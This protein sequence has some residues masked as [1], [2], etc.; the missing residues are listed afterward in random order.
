MRRKPTIFPR[1]TGRDQAIWK[2]PALPLGLLALAAIAALLFFAAPVAAQDFNGVPTVSFASKQHVVTEP[3]AGETATAQLTV[4]LSHSVRDTVT[5]SYRTLKGNHHPKATPNEDYTAIADGE[6]SIAPGAT[7]GTAAVT[8][9][10]DDAVEGD[11]KFLVQLASAASAGVGKPRYATVTIRDNDMEP[12]PTPT[13]QP[14]PMPALTPVR[15]N[16]PN[17]SFA[18]SQYEVDEPDAGEHAFVELTVR[19]SREVS[20]EVSVNY[21]TSQ[22]EIPMANPDNGHMPVEH[23]DGVMAF[24]PGETEVV[25]EVAVEGDDAAEGDENFQVRLF[26]PSNAMLGEPNIAN[27]TIRDNDSGPGATPGPVH[28]TDVTPTPE[29]TPARSSAERRPSTRRINLNVHRP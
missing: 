10:G 27:V 28:T 16:L 12:G 13:P 9:L 25:F 17:V 14:T 24:A 4:R 23:G 1:L 8:I 2:P 26:S 19:L 21:L 7:E 15:D 5:V 22:A 3:D 18:A 11:E 6:L 20:Y 29:P